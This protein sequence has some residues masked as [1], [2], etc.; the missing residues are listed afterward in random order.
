MNNLIKIIL[1]I[2]ILFSFGIGGFVGENIEIVSFYN[3][4]QS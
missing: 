3:F 4:D 1:V 2:L